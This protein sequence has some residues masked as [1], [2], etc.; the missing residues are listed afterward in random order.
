MAV[1]IQIEAFWVVTLCSSAFQSTLLPPSS[2]WG[3]QSP[4]KWYPT[5][6]LSSVTNQKDY[7]N[8]V[9]LLLFWTFHDTI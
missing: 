1:K 9:F 2:E 6:T 8:T 7:L 4:P 5:T 3:N